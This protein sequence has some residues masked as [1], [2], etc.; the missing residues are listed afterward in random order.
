MATDPRLES[1]VKSLWTVIDGSLDA[2][3]VV[4]SSNRLVHLNLAMK[5][6]LGLKARDLQANP[7]LCDH[8]KLVACEG[9]CLIEGLIKS[10]KAVRVDEGPAARGKEKVRIS[11][12]GVP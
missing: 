3:C 6:L 2:V 4:D 8:L 1:L 5:H 10:G 11:L 12:K 7:V 9:G